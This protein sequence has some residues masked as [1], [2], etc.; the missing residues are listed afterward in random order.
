MSA[1]FKDISRHFL[2]SLLDVSGAAGE[3]WRMHQGGYWNSDRGSKI[4][5]TMV[6][7]LGTL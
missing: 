7:V 6:A 4:G 2:E 1:K 5:Q 3:H